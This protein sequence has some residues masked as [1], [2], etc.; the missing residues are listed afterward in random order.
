MIVCDESYVIETLKEYHFTL[1][2]EI[3]RL[4]IPSIAIINAIFEHSYIE[5]KN[6]LNFFMYINYT[7]SFRVV[8]SYKYFYNNNKN[9]KNT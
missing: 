5:T 9:L 2:F 3:I 1:F 4:N 8:R 6:K 7:S